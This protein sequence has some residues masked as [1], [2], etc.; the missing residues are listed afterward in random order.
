MEI[1]TIEREIH[2]E[3]SPEVV[4]RVVSQPEHLRE[5]W[6]EEAELV[7]VP[8][9]TGSITF[10]RP[11]ATKAEALTVVEADPPRRFSFRWVADEGES[12]KPGSSLL[13]TFD[14]EAS[15]GGTLLRFSETGFREKG[16]EAAVLEEAYRDHASGW[17]HFLPRLVTYVDRLVS[18]P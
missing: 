4:Y 15:G 13:V 6:P 18:T 10:V 9:G 3:A 2:I 17:D 5:W 11:E 1:G 16:W 7:A 8:G 12:A 14:L